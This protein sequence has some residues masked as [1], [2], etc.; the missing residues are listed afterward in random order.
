MARTE[1]MKLSF[2][3]IFTRLTKLKWVDIQSPIVRQI[4]VDRLQMAVALGCDGIEV[5]ANQN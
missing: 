3:F 2:Y 5:G 1:G 4:M